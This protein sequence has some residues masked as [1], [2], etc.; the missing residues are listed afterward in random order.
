MS[1][2]ASRANSTDPDIAAMNG[3][4]RRP[5]GTTDRSQQT[6]GGGADPVQHAGAPAGMGATHGQGPLAPMEMAVYRSR[7]SRGH[8]AVDSFYSLLI[9][10]LRLSA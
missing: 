9:K 10:T 6:G 5:M 2:D 3:S 8:K 7:E 4:T 1:S